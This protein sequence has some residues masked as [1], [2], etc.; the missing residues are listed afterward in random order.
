[1]IKGMALAAAA[2]IGM[3]GVAHAAGEGS[4]LG[5]GDSAGI[6]AVAQ[7]Y[8]FSATVQTDPGTNDREVALTS[9]DGFKFFVVPLIVNSSCRGSVW[10]A[11]YDTN[12]GAFNNII[13]AFNASGANGGTATALTRTDGIITLARTDFTPYGIIAGNLVTEMSAFAYTGGA[14]L[15]DLRTGQVSS[16]TP[17]GAAK[18][19]A[20]SAPVA[21][22]A[23]YALAIVQAVAKGAFVNKP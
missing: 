17:A 3:F 18:A 4:V 2:A 13:A 5:C 21:G 9:S 8:G 16:L 12:N 22:E 15:S 6:A 1:M 20:P 14:F 23:S 19:L 10:L 7:S 11:L